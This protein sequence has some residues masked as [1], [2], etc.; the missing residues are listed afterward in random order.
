MACCEYLIRVEFSQSQSW[1]AYFE[2]F[3]KSRELWVELR[4]YT[5]QVCM[6]YDANETSLLVLLLD[7][8]LVVSR[9]STAVSEAD[10]FA[11]DLIQPLEILCDFC[12]HRTNVSWLLR[13]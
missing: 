1:A 12:G 3:A 4:R 8:F 11:R 2:N 6:L 5:G 7:H 10:H 9:L 13:Q